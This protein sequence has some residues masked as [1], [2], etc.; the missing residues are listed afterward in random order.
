MKVARVWGNGSHWQHQPPCKGRCVFVDTYPICLYIYIYLYNIYIYIYIDV[1]LAY[2]FHFPRTFPKTWLG[3]SL[4]P[5]FL[6]HLGFSIIIR[7]FKTPCRV[8]CPSQTPT[9]LKCI[10]CRVF[11]A[12]PVAV[13]AL[14]SPWHPVLPA[15]PAAPASSSTSRASR[16]S[17]APVRAAA[18]LGV[19][20]GCVAGR[21]R[22]SHVLRRATWLRI[23]WC[24]IQSAMIWTHIHMAGF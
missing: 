12:S 11:F 2:L 19:A 1:L 16:A 22:R 24:N 10:S 5:W 15:L 7:C 17:G 13:M 4:A 8:K 23:F 20:A 9:W 6:I 21:V 18:G 14:V 3:H